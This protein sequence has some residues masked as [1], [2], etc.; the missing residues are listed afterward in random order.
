[1]AGGLR[2]GDGRSTRSG[3]SPQAQ[4]PPSSAAFATRLATPQPRSNGAYTVRG[5]RV[6]LHRGRRIVDAELNWLMALTWVG[7]KQLVRLQAVSEQLTVNVQK[8]DGTQRMRDLERSL[9]QVLDAIVDEVDTALREAEPSLADEFQRIVNG[10]RTARLNFAAR[11]ALLT[12]WLRGAV[13]AE[14]LEVRIRVG[15]DRSRT[16]S[17]SQPVVTI[18]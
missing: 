8:V 12:G 7:I 6:G 5:T 1:M 13:E 10:E 4:T 18:G 3:E 16:R 11:S 17:A 14:T 9:G 2:P 15:E